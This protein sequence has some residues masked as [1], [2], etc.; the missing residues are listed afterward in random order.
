MSSNFELNYFAQQHFPDAHYWSYD[1]GC[2]Y[3]FLLMKIASA[4]GKISDRE[5]YWLNVSY[6]QRMGFPSEI[7]NKWKEFDCEEAKIYDLVNEIPPQRATR[8]VYDG[9]RMCLADG[10]Y[11]FKE[12]KAV[13]LVA[14]LLGVPVPVV[15]GLELLVESELIHK[16]QLSLYLDSS[17][18]VT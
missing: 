8:L 10:I 5:S 14:S 1:E 18:E 17:L 13:E 3:G 9:I 6:A 12:K 2:N 11:A 15:R 4:D 16:K 7:V